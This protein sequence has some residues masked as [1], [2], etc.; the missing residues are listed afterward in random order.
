M[1][2]APAPPVSRAVARRAVW[3]Q[4]HPRLWCFGCQSFRPWWRNGDGAIGC[5]ACGRWLI[6]HGADLLPAAVVADDAR[7][8]G[9]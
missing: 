6:S 2:T 4:R 9:G 5:R 3:A 8:G 1:T 7:T